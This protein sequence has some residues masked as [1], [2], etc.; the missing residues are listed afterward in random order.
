MKEVKSWDRYWAVNDIRN[1][2][3][4]YNLVASFYRRF[5]IK[6]CLNHF[7]KK[8]F[9]R[10]SKVLHAGCG[11]GEVDMDIRNY[12]HIT[13][14]DFSQNALKK[15]R[16]RHKGKCT[17][18]KGDVRKLKFKAACFD[19]IYNSGV[20]EHF[21]KAEIDKILKG[22]RRVLK[23]KGTLVI[24]WPPEFGMSVI[25]FK[26]LVFVCRNI[27]NIKN[28]QFHPV[29]V[30]RLRSKSEAREIFEASGFRV[31]ECSYGLRDLF[32]NIII[33]ARKI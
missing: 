14:L 12:L 8:Y 24:F 1:K 7:M 26:I 9:K 31:V 27:L 16:E 15:Y 18:L 17:V 21:S 25:F 20:L 6:P 30:S 5:L 19:G 10:N 23:A 4:V 22:F 2:R 33:V 28:V 32:T 11:G 3:F 29:E 13:A